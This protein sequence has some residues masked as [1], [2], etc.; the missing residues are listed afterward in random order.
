MVRIVVFLS[1]D[2]KEADSF[3]LEGNPTKEEIDNVIME[4]HGNN[5]YYSDIWN[6][7]E[8]GEIIINS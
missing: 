7:D 3:E 1:E 5:W 8:N 2:Y 6:I 4:K